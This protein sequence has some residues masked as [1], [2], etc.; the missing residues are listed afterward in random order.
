[1]QINQEILRAC[2][3]GQEKAQYELYKLCFNELMKISCRYHSDQQDAVSALNLCFFKILTNLNKYSAEIP[4]LPWLKRVAVNT[5]IDEYRKNRKYKMFVQYVDQSANFPDYGQ[6]FNAGECQLNVE[7]LYVLI[8]ELPDIHGKVFNLYAIDGYSHA[9]IANLLG[10]S[11]GT[12]KWYLN[13]A[14]K[15]LQEKIQKI[16]RSL[17]HTLQDKPMLK[18][19]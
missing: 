16:Q 2:I 17:E 10:F 3:Q 8:A 12:S 15:L 14:R 4:F 11:D 9:E 13:Q 1:M 7:Q 6:D 5:I 18:P 19:K